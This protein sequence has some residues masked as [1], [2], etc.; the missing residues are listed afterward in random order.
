MKALNAFVKK[1]RNAAIKRCTLALCRPLG[2]HQ[3]A[4]KGW[5]REFEDPGS[6]GHQNEA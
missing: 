1:L 2:K 5:K 3:V 6:K 4:D